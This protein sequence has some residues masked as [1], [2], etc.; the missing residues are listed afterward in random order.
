MPLGCHNKMLSG[1]K[2]R[3]TELGAREEEKKEG[4]E[5]EKERVKDG[6]E[7]RLRECVWGGAGRCSFAMYET[8][9]TV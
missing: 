9:P 2:G 4:K 3:E 7:K 8:S 5:G 6:E 1:R